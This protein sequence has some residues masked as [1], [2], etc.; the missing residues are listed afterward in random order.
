MWNGD[1]NTTDEL[2]SNPARLAHACSSVRIAE[3]L[4]P[5]FS[6]QPIDHITCVISANSAT[7]VLFWN[8]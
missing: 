6:S 5:F 3:I 4:P 1:L 2:L 7:M 8:M